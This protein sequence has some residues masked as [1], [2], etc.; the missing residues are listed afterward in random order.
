MSAESRKATANVLERGM[1]LL[2]G[3]IEKSEPTSHDRATLRALHKWVQTRAGWK[4]PQCAE[5]GKDIYLPYMVEDRVWRRVMP[6]GAGHL[7]FECLEKRL[8]RLLTV[9]DFSDVRVNDPLKFGFKLG[10]RG[11]L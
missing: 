3:Y 2:E 7:H 1:R 6:N 11:P 4:D 9:D 10:Q 5:C 8:G